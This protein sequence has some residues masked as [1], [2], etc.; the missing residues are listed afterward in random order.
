MRIEF[1]HTLL[2]PRCLLA[3]RALDRLLPRFP[4]LTLEAIE[5]AAHPA[6][7]WQAG[8]RMVPA[9]KINGAILSGL[10]L[11]EERMEK[12]IGSA[13]N[14]YDRRKNSPE[15]PRPGCQGG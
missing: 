7:A 10:T 2:C 15:G 1:Y 5:V 12:F 4:G 11:S 14:P 8:I 3:K 9:L 13:L 6:V